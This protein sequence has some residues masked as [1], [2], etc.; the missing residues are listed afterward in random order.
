M[1]TVGPPGTTSGWLAAAARE[2][3]KSDWTKRRM[4]ALCQM[5]GFR[6]R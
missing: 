2:P 5:K 6:S 3:R 1:A 4:S